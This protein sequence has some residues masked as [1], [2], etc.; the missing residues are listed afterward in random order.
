[1][2]LGWTAKLPDGT[3][4]I[5]LGSRIAADALMLAYL[6][7]VVAFAAFTWRYIEQ[8]GQRAFGGAN[9]VRI[10]SVSKEECV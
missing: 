6:A 2:G 7:V 4:T 3:E 9:Y 8:P 1:V 10:E 5:V